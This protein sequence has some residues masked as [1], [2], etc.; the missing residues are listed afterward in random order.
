LTIPRQWYDATT[1]RR[2]VPYFFYGS[3]QFSRG[4][5]SHGYSGCTKIRRRP[6]FSKPSVTTAIAVYI[7]IIG[8]VYNIILR[9][10]WQPQGSQKIADELL[11]VAVP[12]LYVLYWLIF[13]K[14]NPLQWMD[15]V[16]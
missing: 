6:F 7:F 14:K 1:G 3:Q 8:L 2:Q 13:A 11:H 5:Q 16:K 12:L 9:N 4:Y 15:A 10:L